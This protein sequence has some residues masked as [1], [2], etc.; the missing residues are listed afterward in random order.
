MKG[1][2]SLCLI[3]H[4]VMKTCEGMETHFYVLLT[5]A[6]DG[7]EWPVLG[8][9]ERAYGTHCIG[10]FVGPRAGPDA[11]TK[12]RISSPCWKWNPDSLGVQP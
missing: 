6:I 10:V 7:N 4:L 11:A 12:M 3:K 8:S 5:S 9:S 2:M 1:K